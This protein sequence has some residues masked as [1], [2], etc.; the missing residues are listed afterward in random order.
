MMPGQDAGGRPRP[1]PDDALI[2]S[3]RPRAA[4]GVARRPHVAYP[5]RPDEGNLPTAEELFS[6]GTTRDPEDLKADLR[7]RMG[8]ADRPRPHRSPGL[9]DTHF[10]REQMGLDL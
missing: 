2:D 5:H 3:F 6:T 1:D 10:L 8:L 9:P 7:H 4:G